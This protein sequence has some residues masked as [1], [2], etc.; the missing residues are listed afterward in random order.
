MEKITKIKKITEGLLG[1]TGLQGEVEVKEDLEGKSI[2]I[3]ISSADAAFL[4]GQ[5]GANLFALQHLIRLMARKQLSEGGAELSEMANIVLDINNYRK[6]RAETIKDLAFDK[7]DRA[8]R[9]NRPISLFPMSSYE[10]RVVHLALGGR[11][12]V[13]CQSEGEGEERHIV[14][15]PL[16]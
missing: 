6:D 14:I 10:R 7:A 1:I 16:S 4:I 12:D 2:A 11:A 13:F 3:D 8:M 9:E 5:G 15:R